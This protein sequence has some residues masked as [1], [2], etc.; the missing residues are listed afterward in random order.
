M[1]NTFMI[2]KYFQ[3]LNLRKLI[4]NNKNLPLHKHKHKHLIVKL[5]KLLNKLHKNLRKY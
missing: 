3:L 2:N 4:K 1:F 5:K